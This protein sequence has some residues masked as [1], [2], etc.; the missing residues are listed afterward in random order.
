MPSV[1]LTITSCIE[2]HPFF[3][4]QYSMKHRK[5]N[6]KK[7]SISSHFSSK[8]VLLPIILGLSVAVFMMGKDFST[9]VYVETTPG[10]GTHVWTDLNGNKVKEAEELRLPS[11]GETPNIRIETQRNIIS[12][13][14]HNWTK[15]TLA[16]L[17]LAIAMAMIRDFFYI[18]RIRL[19]TDKQLSWKQSFQVIMMWEFGS[20]V[21]P[22]IVGGSALAFFIVSLEGIPAGRSTAIVMST[23]L[24]DELF[25]IIVTPIMIFFVGA[26][27]AFSTG[28][29]F[30]FL[31]G[32]FGVKVIFGIGY[33]FMCI[34]SLFILFSIFWYPQK[35]K[36]FL[37]F[38]GTRKMFRKWH[39]NFAKMGDDIVTTSRELR[40]KSVWFWTKAY[41]YTLL[42]WT[43]RF[44]V[45]NF[46][47]LTVSS[48]GNHI[49][50][51]VRQLVMWIILCISPTPGSTGIAEFAF[52]V[53][54]GEF[55]PEG[56]SSFLAV[57]WRIFTYY[58]YI[59]I[60]LI[61]LPIWTRRIIKQQRKRRALKKNTPE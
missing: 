2:N 31:S 52:P 6:R 36:Q 59:I 41:G 9:P 38:L 20:A 58:P 29:H 5:R 25:Y 4:R 32:S 47:L 1:I 23:A 44:F 21:T 57:A 48:T 37:R 15:S 7:R 33:G 45:V 30:A 49:L 51:W 17:L 61:V 53:F 11:M 43:A 60:G 27:L 13:F 12:N 42:S 50:I 3:R 19:L 39:E 40:G 8:R 16:F 24:L 14:F 46:L 54:L 26:D 18:C 56:M 34:L 35:S 10:M 22:S 55:I 28:T